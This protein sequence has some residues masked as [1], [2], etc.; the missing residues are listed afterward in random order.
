SDASTFEQAD[1]FKDLVTRIHSTLVIIPS[2]QNTSTN[3][4]SP[5]S[6]TTNAVGVN[7]T[8]SVIG[9]QH[10]PAD[11]Q[12]EVTYTAIPE[13]QDH[14]DGPNEDTLV[15]VGQARQKKRKRTKSAP[16]AANAGDTGPNINPPSEVEGSKKKRKKADAKQDAPNATV[17]DFSTAPNILD[18]C[19]DIPSCGTD[20][21]RIA[22]PSPKTVLTISSGSVTITINA[23]YSDAH[24]GD[25]PAPPK[26]RNEVRSGNQSFTFK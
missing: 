19:Q 16:Q 1:K 2:F 12:K 18:V 6:G 15:V 20:T 22:A 26:P 11:H 24:G 8:E 25:F 13:A 3:S 7:I 5:D 4:T 21:L 17:F 14:S 23:F 10:S 9:V